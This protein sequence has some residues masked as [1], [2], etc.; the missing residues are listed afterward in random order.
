[1]AGQD[2]SP[3]ARSRRPP[4]SR[5]KEARPAEIVDAAFAEFVER[6]FEGA[7]LDRVAARAG[8]SKPTIYLYFDGKEALFEAVVRARVSAVFDE[9]EAATA[10][11][12]REPTEARLRR[13]LVLIY[14][15]FVDT[16]LRRVLKL[17]IAEGGRFPDLLRSYH[18]LA[19]SRGRALIAATLRRG[20]ERGEVREGPSSAFPELVIA[21]AIFLAVHRE[22]MGALS[23]IDRDA[24]LEGHVELVL[25]GIAAR[26]G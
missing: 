17:L 7:R 22:T 16:D 14:Q 13:I 10:V 20:I 25:R 4:R 1:M 18:D 19:Y 11:D 26:E 5:R 21:P 9:V 12:D 8:V 15:R 23:P 24:F 6:G 2:P 3:P